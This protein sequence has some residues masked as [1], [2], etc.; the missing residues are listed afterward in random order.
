[1]EIC[2]IEQNIAR[3]VDNDDAN[4]TVYGARYE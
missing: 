3:N 2:F 4:F 1:M